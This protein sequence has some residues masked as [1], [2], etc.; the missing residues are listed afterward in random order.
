MTIT[1]TYNNGEKANLNIADVEIVGYDKI[2]LVS[3]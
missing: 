2:R 1:V 3:K